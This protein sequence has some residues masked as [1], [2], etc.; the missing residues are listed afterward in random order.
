MGIDRDFPSAVSKALVASGLDLPPGGSILVSIADRNKAEAEAMIKDLAE[1]GYRFY[2]TEG[3]AKMVRA[4]G[5]PVVD[6]PKRLN[7][8]H[9]NVVDVIADGTVDA[10]VNTVTGDRQVLQDGFHIR[11]AAVDRRIPCFTSLDTARAAAESLTSR[12]GYQVKPLG[13]YR[14]G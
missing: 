3:T 5:L 14:S 11:R 10:V 13:E 6:V 1:A 4:M 2:A 9:P 8:G 7:E 12:A